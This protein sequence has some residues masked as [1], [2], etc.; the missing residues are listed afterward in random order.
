LARKREDD[1]KSL[2]SESTASSKESLLK[3]IDE[4]RNVRL[5]EAENR[6]TRKA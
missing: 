1:E 4:K 5:H 6:D 3:E 2:I